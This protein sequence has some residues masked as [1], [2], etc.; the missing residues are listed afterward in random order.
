MSESTAAPRP[1]RSG[2]AAWVRLACQIGGGLAVVLGGWSLWLAFATVQKPLELEALDDWKVD[3]I[4][5]PG[6]LPDDAPRAPRPAVTLTHVLVAHEAEPADDSS[7]ETVR[8]AGLESAT[9]SVA[10]AA[11]AT[12]TP[13]ADESDVHPEDAPATAAW[14]TGDI[15]ESADDS[16]PDAPALAN[17]PAWKRTTRSA[18]SSPRSL[19]VTVPRR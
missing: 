6:V 8:F 2:F 1:V 13:S 12:E 7:V 18:P 10:T 14:L 11:Y 4:S 17:V 19:P 9:Q 3:A 15:E 5:E 16:E